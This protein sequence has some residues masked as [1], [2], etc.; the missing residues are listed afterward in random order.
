MVT[1]TAGL[2]I[3]GY[4]DPAQLGKVPPDVAIAHKSLQVDE[5]AERIVALI[6]AARAAPEVS[7]G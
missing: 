1:R 7:P 4:A 6:E 2:I 3:T 5:L